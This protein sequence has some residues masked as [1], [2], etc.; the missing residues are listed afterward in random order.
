M[1]RTFQS[2]KEGIKQSFLRRFLSRSLV[3]A[4]PYGWHIAF[5]L[6]PFFIV[7]RI[8]FSDSV[9]GAPPYTAIFQWLEDSTLQIRLSFFNYSSLIDDR[10][11]FAAYSQ[12]IVVA[13]LS[14]ILCLFIGY[15]IAYG[16]TRVSDSWRLPLLMLVIL[17][18]WTSFLIRVYAW[19]GILNNKGLI[20]NFLMGW[21]II[22]EPLPLIN[23][24]FAVCL[25]IVYS[26]LPFMI[27]PLYATLDKI[28]PL[29]LEAAYDL[30]CKPLK[31]FFTITVPLS[32]R[33]AVAGA[34]LVF[35]PSMGEFVIP[36]LL[37]GSD[38]LM[39]GKILWTEFLVNRDWPLASGL[40]VAM[41]GLLVL[42]ISLFQKFLATGD[43]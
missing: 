41:L 23:N 37:G 27:L 19:V 39:I 30:G 43:D 18:F 24:N 2:W 12:S 15:P 16:I 26:Y 20:N 14:T 8:S 29:L 34:M 42:P 6:I 33:G 35:I 7:V 3:I 10:L 13:G 11:Y 28:N 36:E 21:G 40:A 32:L 4:I 25:G 22:N 17:P 31:A 5:F 1:I 9:L 38:T